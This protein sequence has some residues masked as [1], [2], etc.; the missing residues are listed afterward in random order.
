MI[1]LPSAALMALVVGSVAALGAQAAEAGRAAAKDDPQKERALE[2]AKAQSREFFA[3]NDRNKDGKLT[4]D[5]VPAGARR[6][7]GQVDA[8]KDGV[9]TVEEDV[10]FRAARAA[11]GGGG[12]RQRR[13]AL[14]APDVAN[15]KYGPHS[16]NVFDLWR[17]KSDKP[18]PLVIYYHGGGF[19]GGDK[20][21]I[22]PT[23]LRQLL[24]G[25][26]SVAAANYR[27][28]GAAP[29]PAQMHDC[30]RALQFIRHHAKKHSLDP[31]RVGATGGSAGAGISLWL[32]FHDDLAD[33]NSKDPV[34]R[35]STRISAAVVYGAQSSYDPR[36]IRKLFD[37]NEVEGA[38]IPLFGM[39]GPGDVED[40]KFHPL[41]EEASPINHASAGDAPVMLFYPQP[42]TPLPNNSSGRLHIHHPKFGFV[43]KAKL[44]KLGVECV[45][46]LRKDY[47]KG[48]PVGDYVKFFF[49][50]LGVKA[51]P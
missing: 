9:I 41:F 51:K 31:K 47:P 35:Q 36:F 27:L 8:N 2:R 40:P 10:A 1:G 22:N 46:K 15:V 11:R 48:S 20:R 44:D 19:R 4:R 7:F 33:P 13:P 6:V 37:T 45:L 30:A 29:F 34:A 39:S 12:G 14:P 26:V 32:A 28:T 50:K 24:A 43:L 17:A 21:T 18:T 23:L 3:R 42:N 49:A 16:R 5:E 25:G 38:L